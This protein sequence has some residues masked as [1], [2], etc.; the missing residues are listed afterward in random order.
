L[1]ESLL[2]SFL[3]IFFNKVNFT[4]IPDAQIF[5]PSVNTLI[6]ADASPD[7]IYLCVGPFNNTKGWDITLGK[8]FIERYYSVFDTGRRQVG[9][10]QTN[11]TNSIISSARI[12]PPNSIE[13]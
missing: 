13:H 11:F 3:Y 9:L 6:L 7:K 5:Q 4:L 10:A 1:C 12:G 2:I 8:A